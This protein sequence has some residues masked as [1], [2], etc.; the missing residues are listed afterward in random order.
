[1]S[2]IDDRGRLF[3]R[4]N[5]IDAFVAVALLGLIPLAYGA[6]VL[7][8]VPVPKITAISP[9]QVAERQE[10]TLQIT[11]EDLRPFLDV[12]FG[13][14][15][16]K[17]FLVQ[18]PTRAEVKLPDLPAGTYDLTLLDQGQVLTVKPGALTVG[19]PAVQLDVQAV[20]AFV[21]LNKDDAVL[22]GIK[23]IVQPP[24]AGAP[25]AEVLALRPPEPR[26]SRVK[27]GAN[28][29]ATGTL[30]DLRVPAIIR[31][32]CTVLN[33]ECRVADA[34]AAQNATITLPWVAP[35]SKD[36]T[37]RPGAVQVQFLLDQLFPPGMA[38]AFPEVASV[39]VRFVA[40]PAIL[41]VI[42]AGDVDLSGVVTDRERAVLTEMGTDR[43]TVTSV[44][45]IE[46][47][48]RIS[49]SVQQPLTAFT[50]TVRVPAVFTPSG[51]S[52]KDQ[53]LKVGGAFT[54][55]TASGAM[56]GW[57]LDMNL[58]QEKSR[59]AQ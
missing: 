11:G 25:I 4:I 30:P 58:G 24:G 20:G 50:G 19:A 36:H 14:F 47:L 39:R 46:A 52:Y 49:L 59:T 55:E 9:A 57:V 31:F 8:R 35:P 40:G 28:V 12:R 53:P 18:S 32:H 44:V 56:S 3:G 10:A 6:F 29:F 26:T 41:N 23:S 1:M 33:G 21:G 48:L 43:Q 45:K 15:A 17:G 54:F 37:A 22:I 27:I 13:T 16:S 34:V 2:L 38:A 42:K 51:W 5:L 7:F